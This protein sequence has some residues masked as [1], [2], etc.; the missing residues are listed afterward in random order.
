MAKL[1]KCGCGQEIIIKWW[2][3]YRGIPD[4][5]HGHNF[6]YAPPMLGRK[7]SKETLRK[8]RESHLGKPSPRKG[9]SH[10]KEA[11]EKMSES[12]KEVPL[13]ERHRKSIGIASK[14]VWAK[15]TDIK[16][17]Q[18]SKNIGIGEKGHKKSDES[19]RK[20]SIAHKGKRLSPATE[21][22]SEGLKKKYRDPVYI[23]KM[24][25]A[26][27]LKPNKPEILIMKLLDKLYPGEWKY[28]GDFSFMI[29]GK[30]PDFVNCNGQ[31]KIIELF[32]DYWHKGQ[33]PQ[34]RID[35]FKPFGYDTLVIW[36]RE[37]KDMDA[38]ITRIHAFNGGNISG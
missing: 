25:K 31:K 13:S 16:R 22:T 38:V 24:K 20:M 3:K 23:E 12:H 18:W 21:F 2:H 17:A 29:N 1:C 30:C 5:I 28:T 15:T 34:D 10:T 6:Y 14:K 26:W 7:P 9:A 35:A 36:E 32:G 8:L 27:N 37:L 33:N 19:R 11:R 4:F